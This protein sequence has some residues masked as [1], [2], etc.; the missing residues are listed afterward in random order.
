ME[1]RITSSLGRRK[2]LLAVACVLVWGVLGIWAFNWWCGPDVDPLT[3]AVHSGDVRQVQTLLD[4]GVSPNGPQDEPHLM[5]PLQVAALEGNPEIVAMLLRHGADVEAAGYA[6][7]SPLAMAVDQP[8]VVR[9]LLHAGADVNARD[10]RGRSALFDAAFSGNVQSVKMLLD[11]G[12]AIN[13]QDRGGLTALHLAALGKN[14]DVVSLLIDKGADAG[15]TSNDGDTPLHM[16]AGSPTK[17]SAP[18]V[19]L[20]LS[21]G[22][23]RDQKNKAGQMPWQLADGPGDKELMALLRPDTGSATSKPA[24][25]PECLLDE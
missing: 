15:A 18:I 25:Q 22:A 9:L 7:P 1:Y 10:R 14:L 5:G 8:N 23:R 17:A 3:G 2:K 11:A 24:S 4:A 13:G 21:A 6:G 12:A 20:L 19:R 16:A